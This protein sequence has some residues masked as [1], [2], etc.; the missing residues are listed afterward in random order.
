M[1]EI[2][3]TLSF[4]IFHI[5]L[6]SMVVLL[7]LTLCRY[8]QACVNPTSA[9]PLGKLFLDLGQRIIVA[10]VCFNFSDAAPTVST[11]VK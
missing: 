8:F 9:E 5:G 7:F 2:V 6:W 3:K 11:A 10:H 4:Y 1:L